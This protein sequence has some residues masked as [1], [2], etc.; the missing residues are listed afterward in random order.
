VTKEPLD[1]LPSRLKQHYHQHHQHQHQHQHQYQGAKLSEV[2]SK[3]LIS[4]IC[5]P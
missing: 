1:R 5:N 4:V 2:K 3:L